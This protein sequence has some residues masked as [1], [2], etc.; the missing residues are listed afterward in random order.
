MAVI[1]QRRKVFSVVYQ[2]K[3]NDMVVSKLE[4][5]FSMDQALKRKKEIESEGKDIPITFTLDMKIKE[6]LKIYMQLCGTNLLSLNSYDRYNECIK[7]YI[8]PIIKNDKMSKVDTAYAHDFFDKVKQS[9]VY[10]KRVQEREPDKLISA[11]TV[12]LCYRVLKG[13]FEIAQQCNLYNLN[14]FAIEVDYG[15]IK[16]E[17]N[18]EWTED[19]ITKVIDECTKSKLFICLNLM[20]GC[21]LCAKEALGLMWNNVFIDDELYSKN[22]C[23]IVLDKELNRVSKRSVHDVNSQGIIKLFEAKKTNNVSNLALMHRYSG[24]RNVAIPL[25]VVKILRKWKKI[26]D[27]HIQR[28]GNK[29]MDNSLVI[30][31]RDGSP[32]E[33]R[34]IEKEFKAL[35]QEMKIPNLKLGQIK[36]FSL[37]KDIMNN[38]YHRLVNE[39]GLIEREVAYKEVKKY[40]KTAYKIDSKV[41]KDIDTGKDESFDIFEIANILSKDPAL[42]K[43]LSKLLQ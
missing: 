38:V 25:P 37:D 9:R 21:H 4:A 27:E 35:K 6:Y 19:Y 22:Q 23:Y 31:L 11:G 40:C 12:E 43:E 33:Y 7:N 36:N 24:N 17:H 28:C 34:V 29:Y 8:E 20:F 30:A 5:F 18:D 32:C 42:A 15:H 16:K 13:A 26:Q 1:I 39:L 14:P 2:V 10:D 3:E 41:L